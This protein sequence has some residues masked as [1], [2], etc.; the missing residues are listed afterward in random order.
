MVRIKKFWVCA[1]DNPGRSIAGQDERTAAGFR[2]VGIFLHEHPSR[3]VDTDRVHKPKTPLTVNPRSR[4]NSDL[5]AFLRMLD[6]VEHQVE[7]PGIADRF[8]FTVNLAGGHDPK[9]TRI[10]L[11]RVPGPVLKPKELRYF[12]R[13]AVFL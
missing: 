1:G 4:F 10:C 8:F 5:S 9:M 6:I 11:A 2:L 12:V 7:Q 13:Q 3:L